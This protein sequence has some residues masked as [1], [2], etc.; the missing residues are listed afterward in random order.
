MWLNLVTF[1]ETI[2]HASDAFLE[3]AILCGVDERIDAAVGEPQ[4]HAEVVEP[5]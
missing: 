1:S 3:L 5:G 2:H 4:H